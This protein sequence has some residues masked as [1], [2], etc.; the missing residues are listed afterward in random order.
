MPRSSQVSW[1]L[2]NSSLPPIHLN[3]E[4]SSSRLP[5]TIG[6]GRGGKPQLPH[7]ESWPQEHLPDSETTCH[8]CWCSYVARFSIQ[9]NK[10]TDTKL[11][12][13]SCSAPCCPS[14]HET[15]FKSLGSRFLPRNGRE[16]VKQFLPHLPPR[17]LQN[18]EVTNS[19]QKGLS[20]VKRALQTQVHSMEVHEPWQPAP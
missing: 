15:G 14:D 4:Q 19:E 13:G 2:L 16:E 7:V 1:S 18:K 3:P 20:Q 9:M 17:C 8:F 10:V 6:M 11:G 12:L 5:V